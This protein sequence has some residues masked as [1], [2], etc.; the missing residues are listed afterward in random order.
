MPQKRFILTLAASVRR[1]L[2]QLNCQIELG[3]LFTIYKALCGETLASELQPI[4]IDCLYKW[5]VYW[6]E[7]IS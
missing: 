1:L 3:I 7:Y 4:K 2:F 6:I 5:C